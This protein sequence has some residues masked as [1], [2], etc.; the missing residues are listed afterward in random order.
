MPDVNDAC[1]ELASV[2]HEIALALAEYDAG[3]ADAIDRLRQWI[4]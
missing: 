3:E 4:R 2:K 1:W